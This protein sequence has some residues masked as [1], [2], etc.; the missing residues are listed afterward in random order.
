SAN[1]PSQGLGRVTHIGDRRQGRHLA[2]EPG[3]HGPMP[4]V[5]LTRQALSHWNRNRYWQLRSQHRQPLM[6]LLGLVGADAT[7]GQS[8]SEVIPEPVD[9]IVPA[10]GLNRTYSQ[11]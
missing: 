11:P 7:P 3:E 10:S 4:R 5:S 9:R 1:E 2:R 8:H 6:L